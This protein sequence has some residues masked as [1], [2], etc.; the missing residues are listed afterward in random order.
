[1]YV[2]V[3]ISVHSTSKKFFEYK[4]VPACSKK[5]FF[6]VWASTLTNIFYSVNYCN[7]KN[8]TKCAEPKRLLISIVCKQNIVLYSLNS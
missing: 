4:G 5:P 8:K 1:M 2:C 6:K 7:R 3:H